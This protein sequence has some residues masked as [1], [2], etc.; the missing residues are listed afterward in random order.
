MTTK[1]RQRTT[2]KMQEELILDKN[3]VSRAPAK[4]PRL[5]FLGV[6]WIGRNRM[7]VIAGSQAGEVVYISDTLTANSE[8]ALKAAPK[9]KVVAT[10]PDMLTEAVDGVVIATPS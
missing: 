1:T 5:G 4:L 8:E 2:K 9:A 10:L 3:T 7:E 6:G